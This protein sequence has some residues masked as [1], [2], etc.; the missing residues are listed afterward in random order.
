M[1]F[2]RTKAIAR[3]EMLH[4][5]RDSRSLAAALFPPMFMT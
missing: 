1:N 5:L 4:I 2:R 3:K